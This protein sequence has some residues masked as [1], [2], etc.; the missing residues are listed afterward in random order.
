[1]EGAT[2]DRQQRVGGQPGGAIMTPEARSIDRAGWTGVLGGGLSCSRGAPHLFAVWVLADFQ[3][4]MHQSA[5][6]WGGAA[7]KGRRLRP[8]LSLRPAARERAHQKAMDNWHTVTMLNCS[9]GPDHAM[10]KLC[11]H[12]EA[13]AADC[14]ALPA[15]CEGTRAL[16]TLVGGAG[17]Q[18]GLATEG[19]THGTDLGQPAR[20]RAP[21]LAPCGGA[22]RPLLVRWSVCAVG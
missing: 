16:H 15:A 11:C 18:C 1:M 19:E 3:G 10:R 22:R 13:A 5:T 9:D 4:R 2:A 8:K 17:A 7:D 21:R 6:M 20:C 12:E 14:C